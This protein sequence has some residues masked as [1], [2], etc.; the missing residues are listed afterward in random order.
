MSG[1]L[2]VLGSCSPLSLLVPVLAFS[3]DPPHCCPKGLLVIWG[4]DVVRE[5]GKKRKGEEK[6]SYPSSR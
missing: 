5:K 3:S 4:R 2:N 6:G 1:T